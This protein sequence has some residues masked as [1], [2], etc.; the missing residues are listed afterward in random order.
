MLHT[1]SPALAPAF[2][3]TR[4][5]IRPPGEVAATGVNRRFFDALWTSGRFVEP[6]RFNTWPLLS[7]LAAGARDR[8]EIGPG[9]HP[10]LP[11]VGTTFV[12][13]SPLPLAAL[14]ARGGRTHQADA[15]ALPFAARR[16]QLVC[17]FDV[18]EHVEG[19]VFEEI[20]RVA[21]PGARIVFSVPLH[22]ARWTPFDDLVGH[23]R[24]YEPAELLATLR[25]H[26]LEIEQ[27]ASF[28]MEPRSRWIVALAVWGLTH[29]RASALRWYH[30]VLLPLGLRLQRRLALAAGL[31]DVANADGVVIVCRRP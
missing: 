27:S 14:R 30:G 1:D 22:A 12:D 20:A 25:A 19:R 15:T 5:A 18:V 3:P 7:V 4:G 9:L 16:F 6:E 29:R 28:G 2:G 21:A 11:I 23:V 17:A 24:R 10:R 26:G 31:V 8:L 13:A